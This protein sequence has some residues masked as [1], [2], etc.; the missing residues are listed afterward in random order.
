MRSAHGFSV[1]ELLVG[2]ILLGVLMAIGIPGFTDY[3]RNARVRTTAESV[4]NGLQLARAE[5]VRRNTTAR[6]QLVTSLDNNCALNVAGP[7]WVV[8]VDNAA[9]LCATAPS[10]AVPPRIVQIRSG[11]EGSSATTI[12]AG[13]AE[14]VFNS[15]GRVP[16][17]NV[18]IDVSSATGAA[19]A[20][21]GGPVRCLR[22]VVS[23]GGQIRL[24]DPAL[25]PGDAQA[26]T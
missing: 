17:G 5:A 20:A 1:I 22:M 23:P 9:G 6:F 7:N 14:V 15:L 10:D 21:N 4:L 3:L 13:R 26:C 8:S 16:A 2:M 11:A 25:R 18:N 12:A 19:C 24:C